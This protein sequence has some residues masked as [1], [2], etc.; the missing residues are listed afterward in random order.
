MDEWAEIRRL[1]NAEAVPIKQIARDFGIAR[2][3]VRQALRSTDPPGKERPRRGSKVD[4][5]VPKIRALLAD[6]PKMPASVI[7]ERIG[8]EF[9]SS[10]LRAKVAEIRPEYR[11]VDPADRLF[12]QAGETIQC[13]L[14]FPEIEIQIG[15]GQTRAFPVLV[16]VSGY[17]R[18]IEA[19]MIPSRQGGDLT[20]GMWEL[21]R[22]F[23]GCA[24]ELLWDRESAIG[25][26]GKPTILAAT[27]VGT[28]STGLRIARAKDPETKGVVERA[29]EYLETSFLPGR[30]F[31][32]VQDFNEQLQT[33]LEKKANHRKVRSTGARP[34]ER[35]LADRHAMLPLPAQA[36]AIGLRLRT[37]LA[38]DYYVRVDGNDYSVD[39]RYIGRFIDV[40]ATLTQ[41]TMTCNGHPAGTHTRSLKRHLTVTDPGHVAIAANLRKRFQQ[42][43]RQSR[44]RFH[45]DGHQVAIRALADYDAMFGVDFTTTERWKEEA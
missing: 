36:P 5:F 45:A 11:S 10:V 30:I 23:E 44:V 20:A 8:W 14:W 18:R 16:M 31:Q 27:F 42:Q 29:N 1:H 34:V 6:Y 19:M 41:V 4:A 43:T 38:R 2:N 15:D 13:D 17:S 35:H 9:S 25:G 40:R 22:R 24:R 33:W 32:S 37:R 21:L 39:P 28:L 3:T 12:Y 7:A 26:T